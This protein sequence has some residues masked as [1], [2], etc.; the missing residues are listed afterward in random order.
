MAITC[1]NISQKH[2]RRPT[3]RHY[4]RVN[5]KKVYVCHFARIATVG[6]QEGAREIFDYANTKDNLPG[7]KRAVLGVPVIQ[8]NRTFVDKSIKYI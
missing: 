2:A 4:R 3:G 1:K 5:H 8:Y 6:Q 7:D